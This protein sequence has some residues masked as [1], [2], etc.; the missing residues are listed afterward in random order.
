MTAAIL[1][2]TK[3]GAQLALR[4]R[5]EWDKDAIVYAKQGS[6]A[7]AGG[8]YYYDRLADIIKDVY[9]RYDAIIF[10]G[11]AG[12]IIRMI[13]P[14]L[15][16]KALDPAVL[17][18]DEQATHVISLLSGHIGG[19]NQL[20]LDLAA[21]LKADPVITT[22][23][24]VQ[25]APAID[26]IAAKLQAA[27]FNFAAIKK[28]NGALANKNK[29]AVYLSP[30]LKKYAF[31]KKIFLD[32]TYF[33]VFDLT[34]DIRISH[35]P[36]VIFSEQLRP[37][38]G[39]QCLLLSPRKLV[40]G[41]GCRKNVKKEQVLSALEKACGQVGMTVQ[42]I[43]CLTST[44][45]KKE[46]AGLLAAAESLHIPAYFFEHS[47]LQQMIDRYPIEI[48]P[49]VQAQIGVGNVCEAAAL[50]GSKVKKIVL[51]K[52]RYEKVTVSLAWEK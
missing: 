40:A 10:I 30:Q 41:V 34:E 31:Y 46:E 16:H 23:T 27:I 26:L 8:C 51:K 22:A 50:Y 48:S 47:K 33:S 25:A 49:F 14:C 39:D 6:C 2:V 9:F 43:A 42:D 35:A 45:V 20:T 13:A 24:D 19:A 4:I 28:I 32:E 11:A 18:L 21:L 44:V 29:V 52:N 36:C 38:T 17:V 1:A 3:N 5:N 7:E 15:Q 12:I 37:L